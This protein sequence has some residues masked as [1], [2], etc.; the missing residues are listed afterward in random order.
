MPTHPLTLPSTSPRKAFF[1][2]PPSPP[3]NT[4]SF[5]VEP[6]LSSPCFRSNLPLS[7]A[8]TRLSPIS[9]DLVLSGQTVLTYLPAALSVASRPFFPFQQA[10]YVQASLLNPTP[11]CTLFAGLGS[12]NKSAIFLVLSGSCSVLTTPSSTPSFLLP[13]SLWQ[14]WQELSSLFSCSIRLQLVHGHSF[15]LRNDAADELARQGPYSCLLQS[16][17]VSLLL[18]LVSTLVFLELEAYCLI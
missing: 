14:I 10:Q 17:V 4:P 3:W 2:C 7:I 1:V 8:K 18:P 11:F 9:H 5:T 13:Q 16:L 6:T 12:T 15:L